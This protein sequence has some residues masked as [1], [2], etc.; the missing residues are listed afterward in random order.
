MDKTI[1]E[2]LILSK[3]LAVCQGLRA[4]LR[5]WS[6]QLADISREIS[7]QQQSIGSKFEQSTTL[8]TDDDRL[9]CE[10]RVLTE[11]VQKLEK[12]HDEAL[13]EVA[14]WKDRFDAEK[15]EAKEFKHGYSQT[16]DEKLKLEE[17]F[18]QTKKELGASSRNFEEKHAQAKVNKRKL[19]ASVAQELGL[20]EE[21]DHF[22]KQLPRPLD[23]I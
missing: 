6:E 13:A 10:C 11:I 22:T 7:L 19:S 9:E 21:F 8:E 23:L 12:E 18:E 16:I 1:F 17:M 2:D 5:K 20:Q 15:S 3:L 14:S 4:T